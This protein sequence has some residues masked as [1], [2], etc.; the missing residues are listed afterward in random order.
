MAT[1]WGAQGT[2]FQ[3]PLITSRVYVLIELLHQS[4]MYWCLAHAAM[5]A[6]VTPLHWSTWA[7]TRLR[8]D[9]PR[10]ML[11]KWTGQLLQAQA[12]NTKAKATHCPCPACI[13]HHQTC[14]LILVLKTP[15]VLISLLSLPHNTRHTPIALIKS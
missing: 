12:S 5:T 13:R 8:D 11:G 7:G 14:L 10:M 2:F 9:A 6:Q 15:S 3:P 4:G 1:F